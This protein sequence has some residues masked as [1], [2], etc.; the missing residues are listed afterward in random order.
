MPRACAMP[1]GAFDAIV[2]D[3]DGVIVESA[4]IKTEAFRNLF[5][6]RPA[7][8]DRIVAFH[9]RH[10]GISRYEKFDRIYADILHIPLS[11]TERV[12]LGN[13][14][15]ELVVEAVVNCPPVPGAEEALGSLFGTVPLLLA[16]GTPEDELEIIVR[17]RGLAAFFFEVHGSPRGKAEIIFNAAHTHGWSLERMVMIGDAM[18]DYDAARA[19][20]LGFIGRVP[21]AAKSPFPPGTR[22]VHDLLEL[23]PA[24]AGHGTIAGLEV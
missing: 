9:Q 22:I 17:R 1:E 21:A 14:F 11:S 15:S 19:T 2:F 13:R 16:S 5:A 10:A 8:V 12:S 6:A 7:D 20:G 3:F 24:L 4:D 18:T 23:L